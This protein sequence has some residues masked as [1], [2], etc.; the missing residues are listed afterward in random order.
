MA[1]DRDITTQ[2]LYPDLNP[3]QQAEAEYNLLGY[4]DIVRRIYK[5]LEEE[6]KLEELAE[7]LSREKRSDNEDENKQKTRTA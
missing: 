4:L 3:E 2:D 6:G 7:V 1:D 5:R